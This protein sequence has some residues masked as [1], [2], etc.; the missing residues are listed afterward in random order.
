M[1]NHLH[2]TSVKEMRV[3][4]RL[5]TLTTLKTKFKGVLAMFVLLAGLL[6]S[7]LPNA[8]KAE[9]SGT[10][11]GTQT[12][13]Q[14][15]LW[16]PNATTTTNTDYTTRRS[17]MLATNIS[18]A[19]PAHRFYVYVKTGETVFFGFHSLTSSTTQTLTWDYDST[20]SNYFFTFT[21][22]RGKRSM[23]TKESFNL[24]AMITNANSINCK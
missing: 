9:G 13:R 1:K 15:N 18:Y 17:M 11:T 2:F 12:G 24:V 3:G 20:T 8:A 16:V 6:G 5:P 19:P 23:N 10:W 14:S 21:S 4:K 22:G 7:I